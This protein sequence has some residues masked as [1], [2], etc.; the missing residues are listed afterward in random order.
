MRILPKLFLDQSIKRLEL[1]G[2]WFPERSANF[3]S[4]SSRENSTVAMTISFIVCF[5]A[6]T[7]VLDAAS[8]IRSKSPDFPGIRLPFNYSL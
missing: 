7:Q 8:N 1:I 4:V 6:D 2:S 3:Y 5:H